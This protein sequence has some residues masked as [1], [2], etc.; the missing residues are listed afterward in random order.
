MIL[1]QNRAHRTASVGICEFEV[2]CWTL[3]KHRKGAEFPRRTLKLCHAF[4]GLA[5]NVHVVS[6]SR[7]EGL[8]DAHHQECP[9]HLGKFSRM[10]NYSISKTA[11]AELGRARL[12]CSSINTCACSEPRPNLSSQRC[13]KLRL[14]LLL[15]DQ[16]T[17]NWQR[18][19]E[20]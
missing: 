7:L 13:C 5:A 19:L 11:T 9:I 3:Y 6:F 18:R 10:R 17:D 4:L 1:Y 14:K 2:V 16:L 8:E 20:S 12:A 15:V